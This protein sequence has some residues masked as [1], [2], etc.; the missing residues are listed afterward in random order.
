MACDEGDTACLLAANSDAV[1]EL[2]LVVSTGFI[3]LMQAGF[4]L[5]ENGTVRSKNSRNILIK[6]MFD[7]AA[8]A[9]MFFLFGF[10]IAFGLTC[11][12]NCDDPDNAVPSRFIGTQH[13]AGTGFAGSDDNKYTLWIFQYSFAATASTIVSGSL[14]ERTQLPSYMLFSALMTGF[15]YPV[16]VAWTW[17]G[18]WLTQNGFHDF[19][20]TGIVHMVGGVAGLVGALIIRPRHG[21]EKDPALRPR[22]DEIEGY[23]AT[24][25]RFEDKAAFEQWM[26]EEAN[27]TDFEPNSIP[28]VVVG[29]VVLWVS[30]L[31]FNG[32]S[33]ASMYADRENG[34]S[35]IILNTIL[36]GTCG[37]LTASIAKPLIMQ[38]YS[39]TRRYDVSA[40]C[41]G[42]LAG[43]VAITGAC[44]RVDPWAAIVIGIV[45]GIV[46]SAACKLCD[47]M[48]ADDPIEAS[49]VHGF[50]GMWGLIAV[51]IFDNVE[52]LVSGAESGKFKFLLWQLIGMF[53]IVLWVA[54]LSAIYFFIMKKAGL[55]RVD[56][57]EEIMGLDIAE[58]GSKLKVNKQMEKAVRRSAS[59]RAAGS[60]G[61]GNSKV[62][63]EP[64]NEFGTARAL[65]PTVNDE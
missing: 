25:D 57:L 6:N 42:L 3:L 19:A 56:L 23:K 2:L 26:R 45:G 36:S 49:S 31:F 51:G 35:K 5:V 18:G 12:E 33:T 48:T 61:R 34:I 47:V 16:V 64:V 37:G 58:M 21:K 13:F 27:D 32:G 41:N 17:G 22:V 60:L 52:G 46:Y 59:L 50:A 24:V 11:R 8:G 62:D 10:G 9:V 4:A 55:L 30:W 54:L 20:G 15:I 28:F 38:T 14:A 39:H 7:A 53:A 65:N 44:D 29:T 63:E 43:L 1:D 40:L